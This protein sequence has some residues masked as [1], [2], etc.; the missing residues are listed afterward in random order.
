MSWAR[1]VNLSTALFSPD[2]VGA[3]YFL[4]SGNEKP[5]LLTEPGNPR[6]ARI[7]SLA[8]DFSAFKRAMTKFEG[9]YHALKPYLFQSGG[10]AAVLRSA[11]ELAVNMD[12]WLESHD[13]S[14]LNPLATQGVLRC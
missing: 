12:A 1:R 8:A 7:Q 2:P 3:S 10:L 6:M 13:L 4:R 5:F 9:L 11:P 14:L